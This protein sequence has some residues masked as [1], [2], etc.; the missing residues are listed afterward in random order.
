[1]LYFKLNTHISDFLL[2]MKTLQFVA[3]YNPIRRVLY[4]RED[5][6]RAHTAGLSDCE[7]GQHHLFDEAH[8][9]IGHFISQ[10]TGNRE[11]KRRMERSNSDERATE[12]VIR[13]RGQIWTHRQNDVS[14]Q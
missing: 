7:K 12:A 6:A 9:R 4:N 2:I 5:L 1:M 10:S 3:F 11:E 8:S 13:S 14:V